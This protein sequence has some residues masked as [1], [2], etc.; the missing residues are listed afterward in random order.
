[1]KNIIKYISIIMVLTGVFSC[2]DMFEPI[3]QNLITS[4]YINSDP[5]SA[6]GILLQGY[7]NFYHQFGFS[8]AATDDAV[9]NQ[10][11][12]AYSR[13]ASGQMS[14]QFFPLSRWGNYQPVIYVNE[15]I[16][17]LDKGEIQW[18]EDHEID[19][20][21]YR[22][23]RGE[24]LA[25]RAIHHMYILQAH[26]GEV[27]G[28]LMGVP[29]VT[30][31]IDPQSEFDLVRL[32]FKATIDSISSDFDKSLELLPFKYSNSNAYQPDDSTIDFDK[33]KIV[34]GEQYNLRM[35]GEIVRALQARLALFAASPSFLDGA[36]DYYQKAADIAGEF[37][38]DAFGLAIPDGHLF[39]NEDSDKDSKELVWRGSIEG[40]SAHQEQNHFPPSANGNGQV[41]PTQNLID[42]FPMADGYPIDNPSGKYTYDP[43]N[44]FVNRD[45]RLAHYIVTDGSSIGGK[46]I[47]TGV[48]GGIDRL[49]SI[50]GKS[51]RTGYYLRKLLHP[52]VRINDDG[53]VVGQRHII[54]YMRMTE[55][56]LIFAEAAN[57]IGG[58]DHQIDLGHGALFSAKQAIASVRKRSGIEQP[59]RYLSS[60]DS[61][62]EMRKL[63]Q[64]ERRLELCFEGFRFF[65]LRRWG[66][67]LNVVPKGYFFDGNQYVEVDNVEERN[68]PQH[69]T[70]NP[71]PYSEVLKFSALEQNTGW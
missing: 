28:E 9:N 20:L 57:E 42:A 61:K 56:F 5:A 3:D 48:G 69:A 58:P 15:F 62:E 64:N 54:V 6:E 46:V 35:S 47:H 66:L 31:A 22:R 29:Y 67:P 65:D 50:S 14:A 23:L 40:E 25:L 32:S 38:F 21:F 8:E 2:E 17:I 36:G 16:E 39:Y 52:D 71:I 41:N 18:R 24:A 49:D 70:Y 12:H 1:M 45:P 55:L 44:P 53:S 19:S 7:K 26:A 10:L 63:I 4:D 37:V 60:I 51:T 11:N 59:D 34:M 30:E 13:M 33:W 43:Q 68:Y 27:G